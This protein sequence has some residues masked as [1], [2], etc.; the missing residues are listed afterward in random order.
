M[1]RR[2]IA[3][4]RQGRKSS[5]VG[6]AEASAGRVRPSPGATYWPAIKSRHPACGDR[7][8]RRQQF[9]RGSAP[10][11]ARFW[12]RTD[13][14]PKV[15][16]RKFLTGV[17]VAGAAGAVAPQAANAPSRRA[18]PPRGCRRRCRRPRRQI[19]AETGNAAGR[20]QPDR[21]RRRLRL[22]GRRHQDARHQVSAGQ[23]R[24]ELS[25]HPRVADQL[26]RQQ[27]AGVPHL[28]P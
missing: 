1:L 11:H 23:L 17:A 7:S 15:D 4:T 28:H 5:R 22:H 20:D 24:F 9:N 10:W 2:P 6:R 19:A 3:L 18:P 12:A 21:R 25:R 14:G 8:S 16:R 26:R 27:D 13:S